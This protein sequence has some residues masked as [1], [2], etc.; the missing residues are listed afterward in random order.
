MDNEVYFNEFEKRLFKLIINTPLVQEEQAFEKIIT[1]IFQTELEGLK[2]EKNNSEIQIYLQESFIKKEKK[3]LKYKDRLRFLFRRNESELNGYCK[4]RAILKF[5]N[6]VSFFEKL[7]EHNYIEFSKREIEL[8]TF[9]NLKKK[10]EEFVVKT[11]IND[12]E[13]YNKLVKYQSSNFFILEKAFEL[14]DNKFMQKEDY[15]FIKNLK[16][17]YFSI[18]LSSITGVVSIFTSYYIAKNVETTIVIRE[19][20]VNGDGVNLRKEASEN[21]LI[22]GKI[23][24]GQLVKILKEDKESEWSYI[25]YFSNNKLY[26][27]WI[28]S[29]FIVCV[30]EEN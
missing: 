14:Y 19:H 11:V 2:V 28:K 1:K 26:K 6:L 13:I 21:S 25:L 30:G 16:I 17:A 24:K 15:K 9:L 22:L 18:F 10:E 29:K 20:F 4:Y 8:N 23:Y 12:S 3:G 7:K 27:G 5:K